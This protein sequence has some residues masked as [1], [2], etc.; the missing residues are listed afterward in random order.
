MFSGLLLLFFLLFLSFAFSGSEVALFSL[1]SID[2]PKIS[3]KRARRNIKK[4]LSEPYILLATIISGNTTVNAFAA[5]IF[6]ALIVHWG[7]TQNLSEWVKT[8]VDIVSFTLILLVTSEITPKILALYNPRSFAQ[9]F[10]WLI[11][12]LSKVAYPF[13]Y[14]LSKILSKQ[15]RGITQLETR[16]FSEIEEAIRKVKTQRK[17][18]L[19]ELKILDEAVWLTKARAVDIAVPREEIKALPE[20]A[21]LGEAQRFFLETRH[22]KYPVYQGNLDNIIGIFDISLCERKGIKDPSQPISIC[23]LPPL[24]IP[25]TLRLRE[26]FPKLKESVSK[27]AIVVDEYGGFRGLITLWDITSCFIGKIKGEFERDE[28]VGIKKIGKFAFIV[29]GSID[30]SD[31]EDILN[32]SL[33]ERGNLSGFLVQ[34]FGYVPREGEVVELGPYVFEILSSRMEKINRVKITRK[35]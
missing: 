17:I 1:S 2:M 22:R 32:F 24:F 28:I 33:G 35:R 4:I 34:R 29:P 20:S 25:S 14:P 16:S 13:T 31:L 26:L 3:S 23:V 19:E 12:P 21:T 18:E 11:Y 27:M 9:R 7:V 30:I 5:S 10:L 15:I 6:T 8:I